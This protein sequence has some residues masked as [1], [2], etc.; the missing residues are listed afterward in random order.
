MKIAYSGSFNVS[1]VN[2]QDFV[3]VW[4]WELIYK[5]MSEHEEAAWSSLNKQKI[6]KCLAS[7]ILQEKQIRIGETFKLE[8]DTHQVSLINGGNY[9]W[10]YDPIRITPYTFLFTRLSLALT[11]HE[12]Y[13]NI[14]ETQ[15]E[16]IMNGHSP[17]EW[18]KCHKRT[19]RRIHFI[20]T[21]L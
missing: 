7:I 10:L 6:L 16:N 9:F 15:I 11:F 12:S 5:Q 14:H 21:S 8:L 19:N 1:S 20:A 13:E 3:T 4:A 17:I 2:I 18:P